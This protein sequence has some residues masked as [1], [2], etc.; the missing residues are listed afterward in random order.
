MQKPKFL[1]E[2]KLELYLIWRLLGEGFGPSYWWPYVKNRFFGNYLF[3]RL[4]KY[5]YVADPDFELHTIC[6]KQDLW[7]LAWMLRSFL[8]MSG[9][10]P[11]VIIHDDGT[12]DKVTEELIQSKFPN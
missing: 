12:L 1:S 2:L 4:P 6:S 7:M 5:D 11:V 10:R 9:L 8:T 3:R